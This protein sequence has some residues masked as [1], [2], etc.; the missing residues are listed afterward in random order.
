MRR[1]YEEHRDSEGWLCLLFAHLFL[2]LIRSVGVITQKMEHVK[3]YLFL[4]GLFFCFVLSNALSYLMTVEIKLLQYLL[5]P[6]V[7]L[8]N[9]A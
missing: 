9:L 1:L 3:Y 8:Y 6:F 2:S 7:L 5:H 4:L